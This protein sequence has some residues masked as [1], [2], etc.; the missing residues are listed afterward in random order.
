MAKYCKP[1]V[2]LVTLSKQDVI[3]VSG[4]DAFIEDSE[5]GFGEGGNV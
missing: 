2:T 5:W 4:A 1:I 3:M